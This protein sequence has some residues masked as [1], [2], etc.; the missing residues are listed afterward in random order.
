MQ[1]TSIEWQKDDFTV[2]TDTSRM[3]VRTIHRMISNAY[4]AKGRPLQTVRET[5]EHSLCFGLFHKDKQ[6]G[7]ARIITDE[8]TFA[9]LCD[10]IIE[11]DYRGQGLGKWLMECIMDHPVLR[12]GLPMLLATLDAHGLYEKF[13]FKPLPNPEH[14]MKKEGN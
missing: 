10:V 8:T 2:H 1:N 11:S 9:Y 3:D 5:L 4:W 14:Y 7:F 6:I 13:G 12:K